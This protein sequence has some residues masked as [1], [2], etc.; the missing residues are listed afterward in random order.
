MS[1]IPSPI[2]AS[3]ICRTFLTFPTKLVPMVCILTA[4]CSLNCLLLTAHFL[5]G[6]SCQACVSTDDKK[7]HLWPPFAVGNVYREFA[8][9]HGTCHAFLYACMQII[10]RLSNL[11]LCDH[12][13]RAAENQKALIPLCAKSSAESSGVSGWFLTRIRS[14]ASLTFPKTIFL[15]ALQSS[16]PVPQL[17]G[18]N[19]CT[20]MRL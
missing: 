1:A 2:Y 13:M 9:D 11:L 18:S 20:G 10:W 12:S 5:T 4:T 7:G 3:A 6:D 14:R 8:V 17:I 19:P 15:V 16:F